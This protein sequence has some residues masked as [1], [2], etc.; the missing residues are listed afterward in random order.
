MSEMGSD[1]LQ[2]FPRVKRSTWNQRSRQLLGVLAGMVL[3]IFALHFIGQLIGR[4]VGV[5]NRV[6]TDIAARLSV[7]SELSVPTWLSAF[8]ALVGALLAAVIGRNQ[9]SRRPQIMWYGLALLMV[10]VS[11]DEVA[12]L[13]ELLLQG[14]HILADFGEGQTLLGNAWLLVLPFIIALGV[15]AAVFARQQLPTSTL[16]RLAVAA[17]IYLSGALVVEYLSI[18]VDKSSLVYLL[19]MVVLEEALEFIGLWLV[20]RTGLLHI[21]EHEP[22]LKQKI[23]ALFSS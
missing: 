19:G 10:I 3:V 22:A 15:V 20:I 12:A 23:E 5:D 8:L 13:H 17:G 6:V 7:D 9:T 2:D 4:A 14:L 11:L 18:P 1:V 21:A 16:R